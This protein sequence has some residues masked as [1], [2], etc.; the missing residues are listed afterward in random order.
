M[1]RLSRSSGAAS[2]PIDKSRLMSSDLHLVLSRP[3][4][5]LGQA[6][7]QQGESSATVYSAAHTPAV[8]GTN[9]PVVEETPKQEEN[10]DPPNPK[11]NGQ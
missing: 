7:Q 2:A 10:S 5:A 6:L 3:T 8:G 9:N 1:P 11:V 4:S